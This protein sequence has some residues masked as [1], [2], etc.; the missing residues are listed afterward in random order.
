MTNNTNHRRHSFN[1]TFPLYEAS[2]LSEELSK[3]VN[4]RLKTIFEIT[5]SV[6]QEVSNEK[7]NQV[8]MAETT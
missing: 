2:D 3:Y 7:K 4:L 1:Y 8:S 6:L 5:R